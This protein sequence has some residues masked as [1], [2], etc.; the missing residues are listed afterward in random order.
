MDLGISVNIATTSTTVTSLYQY[1]KD[2]GRPT[3]MKNESSATMSQHLLRTIYGIARALPTIYN[4]E[5]DK[6][7]R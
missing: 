1:P 5:P 4:L 3:T 7:S 6:G 2:L